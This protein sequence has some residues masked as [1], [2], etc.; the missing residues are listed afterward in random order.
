MAHRFR[1]LG[2]RCDANRW[3]LLPEEWHHLLKVLRL[4]PG[5]EIEIANG[6]GYVAQARLLQLGK[7]AGELIVESEIHIPAPAAATRITLALGAL[8]PQSADELLPYVIELGMDGIEIFAS[9]AVDK[10]RLQ[11][12]VR[13][14]WDRIAA[15]AM[16][17]CKRPWSP[18]ISWSDSLEQL[19]EKASAFPNKIFLDPEGEQ[20]LARWQPATSGPT[21]AVIGSEKGLDTDELEILRRQGFIGCRI[22]GAVLRATT[23]AI[24]SAALLRQ[25]IPQKS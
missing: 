7:Q 11:D 24:A 22:E 21:L 5:S 23:A 20:N 4:P 2:R 19:I 9:H 12:K 6:K 15:A 25:I 17:Q 1:F 16:K 8:K 13:E 14:R 10:N 3:E 18:E